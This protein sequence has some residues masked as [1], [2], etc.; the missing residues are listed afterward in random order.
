VTPARVAGH[1]DTR[2][3]ECRVGGDEALVGV[4]D[5]AVGSEVIPDSRAQL[6]LDLG[7][8]GLRRPLQVLDRDEM[9]IRRILISA[10]DIF[11]R[12]PTLIKAEENQRIVIGGRIDAQESICR[13]AENAVVRQGAA[14]G[15][16]SDLRRRHGITE[17]TF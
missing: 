14:G 1:V 16:I 11:A 7:A 4:N 8:R 15:G 17:T 2:G 3:R 5:L 6:T 10:V 13:A 9:T 12:L